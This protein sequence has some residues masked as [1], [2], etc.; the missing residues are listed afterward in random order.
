MN[1]AGVNTLEV[2][3]RTVAS[4]KVRCPFYG[5]F[6]GSMLLQC[7]LRELHLMHHG[8]SM[9]TWSLWLRNSSRLG[10]V[11]GEGNW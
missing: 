8:S 2:D 4:R 9:E 1:S 11:Q 3:N 10:G 5:T 6:T 7:F